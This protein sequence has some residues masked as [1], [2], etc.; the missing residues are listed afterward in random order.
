[1]VT[2]ELHSA[3]TPLALELRRAVVLAATRRRLPFLR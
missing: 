2:T 3:M 1:M